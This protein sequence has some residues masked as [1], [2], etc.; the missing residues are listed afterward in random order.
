MNAKKIKEIRRTMRASKQAMEEQYGESIQKDATYIDDV[1]GVRH[2][3]P[4]CEKHY[5]QRTKRAV[6]AGRV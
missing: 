2:L 4:R 3:S 5:V 1:N 6:K